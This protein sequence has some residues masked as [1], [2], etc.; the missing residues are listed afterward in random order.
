MGDRARPGIP[1]Q[2]DARET[3]ILVP[4]FEQ[5]IHDLKGLAAFAETVLPGSRARVGVR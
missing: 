1:A 5:D 4:E 3:P 2:V